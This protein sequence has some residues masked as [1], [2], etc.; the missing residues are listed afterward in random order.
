MIFFIGIL[1][2]VS[3]T[4]TA[5]PFAAT[6]YTDRAALSLKATDFSR[7]ERGILRCRLSYCEAAVLDVRGPSTDCCDWRELV[8][9]GQVPAVVPVETTLIAP[10]LRVT[11]VSGFPV[12]SVLTESVR[13]PS[14]ERKQLQHS[15]ISWF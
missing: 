10:V 11:P 13:S 12:M 1:S 5:D 6:V 9:S 7:T 4:A 3:G 15:D 8:G 2:L 14:G